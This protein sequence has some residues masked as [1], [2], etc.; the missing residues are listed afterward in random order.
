LQSTLVAENERGEVV[1]TISWD[2]VGTAAHLRG[3]T[4]TRPE[5][6]FGSGAQLISRALQELSNAGV[7]WAYLLTPGADTLFESLGF[8][9]VHRDRVPEEILA[10]AQFGGP[11]SGATALVRRLRA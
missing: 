10:T 4:V 6:G 11:A 3:I 9:P 7:E 2:L 1:G 8:W 5:R